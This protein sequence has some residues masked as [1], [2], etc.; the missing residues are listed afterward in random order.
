MN[1]DPIRAEI[2][3]WS[4]R[5]V[6]WTSLVFAASFAG[7]GTIRH[8]GWERLA[9]RFLG[10]SAVSLIYVFSIRRFP[11]FAN[12]FVL[13]AVPVTVIIATIGAGM[14][15][16]GLVVQ[17]WDVVILGLVPLLFAGAVQWWESRRSI[18]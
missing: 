16:Y 3:R 1:K 14:I 9:L 2:Q 11:A 4:V 5:Q 12:I 8:P 18:R 17:S 10:A 7:I 13:N 6:V 15:V